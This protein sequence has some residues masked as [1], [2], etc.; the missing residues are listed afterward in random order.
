MRNYLNDINIDLLRNK[1]K[2]IKI[3]FKI[4][5]WMNYYMICL[6]LYLYKYSI[7]LFLGN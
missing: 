5:I 1:S 2:I 3:N 6:I 7:D 4:V